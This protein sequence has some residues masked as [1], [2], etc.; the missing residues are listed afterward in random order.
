MQEKFSDCERILAGLTEKK[1]GEKVN[2]AAPKV[3][4]IIPAY[5]ISEYVAETLES[6]FAQT[7]TD[8]EVILVNDGSADT[9]ELKNALAPYFDRIVYAEQKNAGAS[10]ARNAAICLSR[11][12]LLAFLD[13]DD[14]WLPEFLA[15]SVEY[16]EKNNLEMVYSDALLFGAPLFAGKTFMEKS[17]SNG[18]V[19]TAKLITSECNIITSGTMIKKSLV[20][21]FDLFDTDLKRMQDFDLWFRLVKNGAR[22]NYQRDVLL[23]YRVRLDSL[24]GTTTDR[25]RRNTFGLDVLREKYALDAEEL[26]A[27]ENQTKVFKAELE[28]ELGKLR[29]LEGKFAE[30]EA[31]FA[32]ANKLSNRPKLALINRLVKFSPRLTARLFK[33]M[34]PSEAAF[35]APEKSQKQT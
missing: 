6:V 9:P 28:L 10:R 33:M 16:L 22:I 23:K 32:E 27:L 19:T 25:A 5:N 7:F 21:K 2:A 18:E 12:E 35:I 31:H 26:A 15:A 24:S 29:L 17:P 1:I 30:A 14:L 8:F 3:S 34:R 4:V 11:G 20:E 13:G